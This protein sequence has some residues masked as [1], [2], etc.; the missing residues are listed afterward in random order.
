MNDIKNRGK[1]LQIECVTKEGLKSMLEVLNWIYG[2]GAQND[3][4]LFV[5]AGLRS[6]DALVVSV[7]LGIDY[8]GLLLR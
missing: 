4:L 3:P 7:V 2:E 1:R 6:I 8:R 5:A